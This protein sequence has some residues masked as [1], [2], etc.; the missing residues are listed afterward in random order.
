MMFDGSTPLGPRFTYTT[1]N[2]R[3]FMAEEQ[4]NKEEKQREAAAKAGATSH[5]VRGK[6]RAARELN[7]GFAGLANIL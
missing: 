2:F 7:T 4:G 3:R 5:T 6:T 1:Q